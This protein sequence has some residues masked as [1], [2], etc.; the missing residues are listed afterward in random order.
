MEIMAI[1]D[2]TNIARAHRSASRRD[3]PTLIV[4]GYPCDS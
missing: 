2:I 1:M 3:R 4:L